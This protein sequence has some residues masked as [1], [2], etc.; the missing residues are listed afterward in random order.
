MSHTRLSI[1]EGL[2]EKTKKDNYRSRT[3]MSGSYSLGSTLEMKECTSQT[4]FTGM[5][6]KRNGKV[7]KRKKVRSK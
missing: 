7:D 5:I 1:R 4:D 6:E 3:R 2:R